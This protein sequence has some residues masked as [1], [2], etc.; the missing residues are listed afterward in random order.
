MKH[1]WFQGV[2]L[3]RT[4]LVRA[5]IHAHVI[6]IQEFDH[7]GAQEIEDYLFELGRRV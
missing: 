2:R 4:E 1:V 6:A 5:L 3:P 7:D